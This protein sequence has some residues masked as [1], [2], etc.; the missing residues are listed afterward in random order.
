MPEKALKLSHFWKLQL[1][2]YDI[3]IPMLPMG[4]FTF[5]SGSREKKQF[6]CLLKY[7]T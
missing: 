2:M 7:L 1:F 5:I 4:C 6:L 3:N